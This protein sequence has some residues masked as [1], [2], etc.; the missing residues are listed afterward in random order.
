M[1]GFVNMSELLVLA[2]KHMTNRNQW[3][4][5]HSGPLWGIRNCRGKNSLSVSPSQAPLHQLKSGTYLLSA[6]KDSLLLICQLSS[7]SGLFLNRVG[8]SAVIGRSVRSRWLVLPG[9]R[10]HP[11]D[12]DSWLETWRWVHLI[13]PTLGEKE[14]ESSA[15]GETGLDCLQPWGFP[16]RW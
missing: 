15:P 14:E 12:P 6:V 13:H 16:F 3:I 5:T 2:H 7:F 11:L 9:S 4:S 10:P 1:P 8:A